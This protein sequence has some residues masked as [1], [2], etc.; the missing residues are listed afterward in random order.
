MNFRG[1]VSHGA[2][3]SFSA[4]NTGSLRH[5]SRSFTSLGICLGFLKMEATCSSETLV[6]NHHTTRCNTENHELHL[7]R[8]E[9]LKA[10]RRGKE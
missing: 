1:T 8:R 4:S 3:R 5:V 9:N 2:S 10:T 7:H 6:S